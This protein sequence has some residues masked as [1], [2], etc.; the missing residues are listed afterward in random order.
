MQNA[1]ATLADLNYSLD[2]RGYGNGL[3]VGDASRMLKQR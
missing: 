1:A 3:A 2:T